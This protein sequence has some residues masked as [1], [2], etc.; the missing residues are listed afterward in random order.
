MEQIAA[1]KGPGNIRPGSFS[2]S[3]SHVEHPVLLSAHDRTALLCSWIFEAE[4]GADDVEG[5][6]THCGAEWSCYWS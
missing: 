6:R 5:V 4:G 3:L 1:G 2:R